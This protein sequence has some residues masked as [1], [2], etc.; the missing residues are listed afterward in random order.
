[1][2][3]SEILKSPKWQKRRLKIFERDSYTCQSC[4][5][6]E[7]QLQVHHIAY[8][9]NPIETPDELL[10]TL[11]DKCHQEVSDQFNDIKNIFQALQ[12]SKKFLELKV[13]MS[14][15]NSIAFYGI[16]DSVEKFNL[17]HDKLKR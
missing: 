13:F 9:S 10:I 15:V 6:A 17:L 4:K 5:D 3:Y 2:N 1:M 14:L 16:P 12:K 7:S 11:C 8:T